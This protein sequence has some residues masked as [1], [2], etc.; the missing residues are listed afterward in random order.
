MNCDDIAHGIYVFVDGEFAAPEQADFEAHL[1]NC[2]HCRGVLARDGRFLQAVRDQAP[3]VEAPDHLRQRISE[4]LASAPAP[5]PVPIA[6]TGGARW[7]WA[8]AAAVIVGAAAAWIV[9]GAGADTQN[10]VVAES[11]ATHQRPLPM[12]VSGSDTMIRRY[13]QENVPFAVELPFAEASNV[14]LLGAR[15]TRVAG[16]DAVLFNYTLD[17]ERMTVVQMA[18]ED[19]V[20]SEP[21]FE[22]RHGYTVA[23]VR[24]RGVRNAIVGPSRTGHVS[25]LVRAAYRP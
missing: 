2:A 15:L 10:Q 7:A 18:S 8:A 21:V 14:R 22:K 25:R 1:R 20:D 16:K 11:L 3:A 5:D 24:R 6:R 23:T 13:L 4:A 9:S 19:D 17:G 12:E